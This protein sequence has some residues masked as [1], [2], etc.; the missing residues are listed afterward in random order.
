MTNLAAFLTLGII[1][2]MSTACITPTKIEKIPRKS[3]QYSSKEKD[4][5]WDR[6]G[7]AS[8]TEIT[9]YNS[10][11]EGIDTRRFKPI[12]KYVSPKAYSEVKMLKQRNMIADA[13]ATTLVI[14]SFATQHEKT[15]QDILLLGVGGWYLNYGYNRF[16]V[17]PN[18]KHQYNSS[19]NRAYGLGVEIDFD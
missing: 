12:I 11:G 6:Y 16:V 18:I 4:L 2:H 9:V 19:L 15:K 10:I 8:Y 5:I 3:T 1:L 17:Y 14:S 13:L 7:I